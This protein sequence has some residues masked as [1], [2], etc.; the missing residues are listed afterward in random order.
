M[1]GEALS[2]LYP[3]LGFLKPLIEFWPMAVSEASEEARG[4][5]EDLRSVDDYTLYLGIVDYLPRKGIEGHL[6][7]WIEGVEEM[8]IESKLRCLVIHYIS[9]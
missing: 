9:S 4:I 8:L 3:E 1:L 6:I 2:L 7:I 5:D